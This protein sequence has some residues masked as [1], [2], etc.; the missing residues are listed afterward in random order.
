MQM[1]EDAL[2]QGTRPEEIGFMSFTKKAVQ[3]AQDRA[4]ARFNLE[5]KQLPWFRTLHS[6][7]FRLLGLTRTDLLS[8]ED[9]RI[10]GQTLGLSFKGA[11]SASPDDGVLIPAIGGDGTKYLQ[12]IDRSRYRQCTLSEEFNEAEDYNMYFSKMKQIYETVTGYKSEN[13]KVDFPDM[14]ELS[15][16]VDAPRLKLLFIDEAQD[17]TPLQWEMVLHW[18]ENAERTVYAGDDR[19]RGLASGDVATAGSLG[20]RTQRPPEF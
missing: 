10:L 5:P 2:E 9:W 12:M 14:I 16:N 19:V 7:A 20:V 13:E 3:E 17:L 1:V 4:C 15:L 18:R 8:L 11:D 6:A